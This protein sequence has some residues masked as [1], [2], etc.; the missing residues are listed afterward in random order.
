LR[1]EQSKG[2]AK[3]WENNESDLWDRGRPSPALVTFLE[4]HSYRETL[5]RDQGKRQLKAFVPVGVCRRITQEQQLNRSKGCGKGHDVVLLARHGFKTWGLEVSQGAV[6]SA[7]ENVK[8]QLNV[9]ASRRAEVVLGDFFKQ[10]YELKFGANFWGFDL[11]YDYT[12]STRYS[13]PDC[14]GG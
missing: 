10:D 8:A 14:Y 5:F 9:A 13:I 3:L 12:V 1:D 2:W 4:E 6:D 7:N 11:I